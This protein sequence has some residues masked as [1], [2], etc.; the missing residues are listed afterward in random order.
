[1]T[2][3][4][5]RPLHVAP[6][7]ALVALAGCA[8]V[9]E[10]PQDLATRHVGAPEQFTE[11]DRQDGVTSD[12][13]AVGWLTSLGDP[14]LTGLVREAWEHNPD[15][16]VAAARFEEAAAR[17]RVAGSYLLPT[18]DA[19]GDASYTNYDGSTDT[20]VY[21]IGA[22]VSWE[23]DLWGRLRS[24]RAAARRTAEAVGLDYMQAR[25]SLAAMVAEGY[26]AI[27]TAKQ[28]LEIDR[29]LLEAERFTEVTTRQR[30]DAG[31][32]TSLDGDLAESSVRLAEASVQ[33]DLAALR[34]AR[35]AMELLLGRYPSAEL[36][37]APDTLPKIEDG[38]LAV[39]VPSQLLERRPDVRSAELRVDAAY[40]DVESARAA[41]L[42]S[43]TL[44]A[45]ATQFFDPSEFVSSVAAGIVAPLFQGGR[46]QAEQEAANARQRQA[47]GEFASV[48]LQAFGEV[49]NALSNEHHLR[50]REASLA[51]ASER[52][53][54]ASDAAINRYDQGLLTILD[55]QQIRRTDYSTR[56]LLLGVRFGQIRQR[57]NLYLA[58]GGPVVTIDEDSADATAQADV[59]DE[60]FPDPDKASFSGELSVGVD[61][62]AQGEANEQDEVDEQV[63]AKEKTNGG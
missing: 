59:L 6:L 22:E 13:V 34:E 37:G 57:L 20:E 18:L 32:G 36:D 41:R 7:L 26:Y 31:L 29:L 63:E 60:R 3:R 55:L 42:P 10:P 28:Q 2:E 8:S 24:D 44:S 9:R 58:L 38:P 46:L 27:V 47:L 35:R 39:G 62:G 19:T 45:D 17:L 48:A 15:L 33:Q 21:S 53:V 14:V 11:T 61:P 52:L 49:E 23:V 16:Y 50:L 54:R 43:L 5:A 4:F 51:L 12:E 56:S 1:M 30:V 40:Y 25:H